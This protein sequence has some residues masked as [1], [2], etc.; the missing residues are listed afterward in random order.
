MNILLNEQQIFLLLIFFIIGIFVSLTF[1]NIYM[2][3]VVL[4]FICIVLFIYRLPSRIHK[5]KKKEIISPVD[6]YIFEIIETNDNF[7][8]V[9]WID[10]LDTQ[11]HWCP[12]DGTIESIEQKGQYIKINWI[13]NNLNN[14]E[15][16]KKIICSMNCNYGN[17]KLIQTKSFLTI[18]HDLFFDKT[19]IVE[20]GKPFG[21]MLFPG[22][23]DLVLPKNLKLNVHMHEKVIGGKTIIGEFF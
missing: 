1:K 13:N 9:F 8:L 6:G 3:Y 16:N 15:K 12:V 11:A 18:D 7:I 2:I 23:I 17:I 20:K 22:R 4:L 21:Y 14:L 10:E 5:C 19:K